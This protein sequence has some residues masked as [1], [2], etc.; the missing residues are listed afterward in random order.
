M[1]FESR[2]DLSELHQAVTEIREQIGK[3]VVG[4]PQTIDLLLTALLADGHILL[5]G[6][7]GVAKTLMAKLLSRTISVDFSRIQFT[8][9]M[10]P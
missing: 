8:P 3:I 9:D 7:P 4:Q 2:I 5:E 10:M 1:N 6:V